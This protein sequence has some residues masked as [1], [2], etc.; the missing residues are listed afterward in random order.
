M[1]EETMFN[2][3]SGAAICVGDVVRMATTGNAELHGAWCEYRIRKAPGGYVFSYLRSENGQ[4]LPEGYTGGYMADSLP[5]EDEHD[6][7]TLVFTLKPIRVN[8]W[9][10]MS[11]NQ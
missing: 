8:G 3:K 1:R 10:I 5:E 6:I 11:A 9:Q 4:I 2:D 7:K